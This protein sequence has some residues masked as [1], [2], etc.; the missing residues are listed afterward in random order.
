MQPYNIIVVDKID[1]AGRVKT[2]I[3]EVIVISKAANEQDT[4]QLKEWEIVSGSKNY[5]GCIHT[6]KN[7]VFLIHLKIHLKYCISHILR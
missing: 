2:I 1:S 7:I 3:T 6:A 5:V 4:N